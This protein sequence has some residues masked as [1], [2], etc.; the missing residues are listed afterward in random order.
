M[1]SPKSPLSDLPDPIKIDDI[2]SGKVDS[3]DIFRELDR[4]KVEV[5]IL[6]NDM[7][8]FLKAL[9]TI[10]Q[11]QSQLEYREVLRSKLQTVQAS[12]RDYCAQYNRL[13]PIINLAQIKLG[14]DAETLPKNYSSPQKQQKPGA[15]PQKN[16][17][18]KKT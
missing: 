7:S 15:L 6:R 3:K 5:N 13:L 11:N 4:L 1:Q 9:A 14:Q 18:K 10:P 2:A 12:I 8:L 16:G 17:L